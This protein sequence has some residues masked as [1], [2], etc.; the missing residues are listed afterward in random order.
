MVRSRCSVVGRF[1]PTT[2]C[3]IVAL[4]SALMACGEGTVPGDVSGSYQLS[5]VNGAPVPVVLVP[6]AT[7]CNYAVLS[8]VIELENAAFSSYTAFGCAPSTTVGAELSE[9]GTF[10]RAGNSLT[11]TR[12]GGGQYTFTVVNAGTLSIVRDGATWVYRR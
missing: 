10:T 1:R 11:V 3:S 2:R 9:I 8:G 6:S 4:V 7:Q 12:Q 5:T